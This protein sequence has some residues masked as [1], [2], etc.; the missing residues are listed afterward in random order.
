M[1][2]SVSRMEVE[3]SP[4]EEP[5]L[6]DGNGGSQLRRS[7]SAPMINKQSDHAPVFQPVVTPRVRRFSASVVNNGASPSAVSPPIRIGHRISQ[8]KREEGMSVSDRETEHEREMHSVMQM[9]QSWEETSLRDKFMQ[10]F[11]EEKG[12]LNSSSDSSTKTVTPPTSLPIP[13]SPSSRFAEPLTILPASL[14]LS[15]SPSPTRIPNKQCFSPSM[16]MS[17]RN[18]SLSPSPIPSPTRKAFVTRRSQSPGCIRPSILGETLKRKL[19]SGDHKLDFSSPPKRACHSDNSTPGSPAAST[20][21]IHSLSS[22]SLEDIASPPQFIN[23]MPGG[24]IHTTLPSPMFSHPTTLMTT[25]PTPICT[26]PTPM[27]TLPN[28]K[29]TLATPTSS[30]AGP[31]VPHSTP[32]SSLS[33]PIPTLSSP[34]SQ[35]SPVF[36]AAASVFTPI[37]SVNGQKL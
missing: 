16:Q 7:N 37:S 10:S 13:M 5:C 18:S 3:P 22:S 24:A 32:P 34:L 28:S 8:L 21:L 30:K 26:L 12:G 25:L 20:P 36:T 1:A 19:C 23:R 6:E 2:S 9:S 27:S 29:T 4:Q 33:S 17:V 14:P 11:S 35:S 15:S 31:M